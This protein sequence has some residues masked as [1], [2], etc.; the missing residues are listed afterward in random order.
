MTVLVLFFLCFCEFFCVWDFLCFLFVC[1]CDFT[2]KG[3]KVCFQSY[4][5]GS[6]MEAGLCVKR[7]SS[8][9]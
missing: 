1:L 5:V 2:K 3:G 9:L 8:H 6:E 4:L 7:Q